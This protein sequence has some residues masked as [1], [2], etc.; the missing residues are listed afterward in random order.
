M[1]RHINGLNQQNGYYPVM[2]D[3]QGNLWT[4]NDSNEIVYY[5]RKK[6]KF[7]YLPVLQ[8]RISFLDL[9]PFI[10]EDKNQKV[11]ICT[12]G[13]LIAIDTRQKS[14][15]I[16]Q[17]DP[18]DRNS[19]SG[20]FVYDIHRTKEGAFYVGSATIDV[21]NKEKKSF[22][23]FPIRDNGKEINTEGAWV[24]YE[25]SK[26]N[27]W[28][29]GNFGLVIYNPFTRQAKLLKLYDD[30]G[31]V[32][33]NKFVGIVE[34]N[35]GRYWAC[36]NGAGLYLVDP[37]TG[38]TRIFTAGDKAPSA[39]STDDLVTIYKDSRGIIYIGAWHGGFIMFDPDKESFK[40]YRHSAADTTSVSNESAHLFH[41]DKNG[42]IWFGTLGGGINVFNPVTEKFKSFTTADGLIHNSISSFVEDKKGNYWI[43]T[44]GGGLSCF[45]PPA[46]PFA[47]GTKIDF[48]NYD[49]SD[50]LPSNQ[51][52]M[53]SS[54]C[55]EDGTLFFG[56]RGAGMI[57]FHPDDLLNSDFIP[58]VY[59]TGLSLKNKDIRVGDPNGIL[60]LPIELTNDL[61][62]NYRQNFFSL[63]FSALNYVH[64]EKNRYAY[65]LEGYDDDWV[66]T[67][68]SKRFAS[69]TNLTPGHYTFKVKGSNNDGVWNQVPTELKII[70]TPPFWQTTWFRVLVVFI[71]VVIA[72]AFY[73]YRIA[74]VL[75]LQRIRNKIAADL[76]DD[77][78]S[79]LNSI[80]VY[81]EVARKDPSRKDF[82][83]SM[84]GESSRKVIDSMSDIVWS[85][86]PENDSFDKII[87]RMRSLTYNLLKAKKIDCSFRTDESLNQLKLSMHTRRNFY[88][89]FK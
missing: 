24:I 21:F 31:P 1:V 36:N 13:G 44:R 69:Y 65:M 77:I 82:A 5:D 30:H 19:I 7:H 67:D 18:A 38:K 28:F 6:N 60:K 37:L 58:P 2:E 85:I 72:Y 78:G 11:W 75:L 84:I 59:I 47:P 53:S 89:I 26:G 74:Q 56:T 70:I 29:T 51:F 81:S 39:P 54:F 61:K 20:N 83:L 10:F 25:D 57:F 87:F 40:T 41:E 4:T 35:K 42:L 68:A 34:D 9:P 86:N 50:G 80:S 14:F 62:L 33:S 22:S 49:L 16:V 27:T 23:R 64:P 76:H 3:H 88:L 43:G 52:N 46:D 12:S 45:T 73:R 8:N 48:R 71:V 15:N 32:F 55:D 79:T 63:S 66:H 17:H